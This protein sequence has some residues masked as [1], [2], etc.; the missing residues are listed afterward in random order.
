MNKK[1]CTIE[2][3]KYSLVAALI[4]SLLGLVNVY[5]HGAPSIKT[6]F[7]IVSIFMYVIIV[8]MNEYI[9]WWNKGCKKLYWEFRGFIT[10]GRISL[11]TACFA[12]AIILIS[13]H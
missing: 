10:V 6:A 8:C 3:V 11:S 7:I 9:S 1:L 4:G 12:A 13:F 5:V 2:F